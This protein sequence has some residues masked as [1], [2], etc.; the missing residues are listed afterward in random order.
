MWKSKTIA[1]VFVFSAVSGAYSEI[2]A[3]NYGVWAYPR[4]GV[5]NIPLW[6]II[7]WGCVGACL[8]MLGSALE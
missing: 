4:P 3:I 7:T 2:I 6:L 5:L 1:I 8:Y